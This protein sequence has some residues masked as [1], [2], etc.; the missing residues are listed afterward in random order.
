ML[1]SEGGRRGVWTFGSEGGLDSRSEGGGL[2]TELQSL[3]E[4]SWRLNSSLREE[5]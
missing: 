3:R 5:G 2:E 4:E 1:G